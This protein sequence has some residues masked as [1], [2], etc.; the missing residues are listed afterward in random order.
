V[1]SEN[2]L[3][4]G[5]AAT[6]NFQFSIF[7]SQAIRQ[8]SNHFSTLNF[9]NSGVLKIIVAWNLLYPVFVV[10]LHFQI[11]HYGTETH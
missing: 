9:S 6:F 8:S 2:L 1:K 7:N 5:A 10:I 4:C 3:T 11:P